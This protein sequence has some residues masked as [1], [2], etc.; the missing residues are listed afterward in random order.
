V[1]HQNHHASIAGDPPVAAHQVS[2]GWIST[3]GL[4][5]FSRRRERLIQAFQHPWDTIERHGQRRQALAHRRCIVGVDHQKAMVI[6]G[7]GQDGTAPIVLQ[8][9]P[10][11]QSQLANTPEKR[12][13]PDLKRFES[14]PE[15]MGQGLHMGQEI[16]MGRQ[17]QYLAGDGAP[18]LRPPERSKYE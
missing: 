4:T 6:G 3:Q 9:E 1:F 10:H 18:E 13:V 16:G 2:A 15:M 8:F 14:F 7:F 11:H 17:F 12:V 5:K